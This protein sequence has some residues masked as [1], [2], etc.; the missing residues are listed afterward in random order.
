M[1]NKQE[2]FSRLGMKYGL[3]LAPMAGFTDRAMRAVCR[4]HGAE[5]S[6]TE[7][8]SAKALAY[9]DKK[10]YKLAKILPDEGRCAVQIFGSEPDVMARAAQA[11]SKPIEDGVA[12]VAIDVNM[13]CPV[14][15]IFSNG[16]G[17]ALMKSPELV[18]KIV[19]SITETIE[20]PCT[21]KIRTGIDCDH[22]SALECAKAAEENGA[23]L[24]TVHGRTRVQMYSGEVDKETIAAVKSAVKIPVLANGDITD[25]K[26]AL[27]MLRVTGA[28]G[29]MIGRG[30]VGNPFIFEEI[31][32]ALAGEAYTPPTLDERI[33]CAL[34]Q[35]R[36]A[37]EEKGE[38]LAVRESRKQ[39]AS[40]LHSFRGAASLRARIN[41]ALTY[42]DV[43]AAFDM[44]KEE[45]A[46]ND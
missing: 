43:K 38:D 42:A 12:P 1:M 27:E 40:Y 41:S 32:A 44:C 7:M 9:G 3:A 33:E 8:V 28:D 18:G 36:L 30:A 22:I 11:L 2:L 10:T 39:I 14:H 24:I 45:S 35:L 15:K 31:K 26:A 4:L 5:Y 13:G 25:A 46:E 29:L 16:E 19:K 17:S 20:I 23:E 21:V 6:V 34:L 37:I